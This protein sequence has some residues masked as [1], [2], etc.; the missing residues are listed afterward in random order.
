MTYVHY[1]ST[2]WPPKKRFRIVSST[3]PILLT[4]LTRIISVGSVLEGVIKRRF[5]IVHY[6]SL[7][8]A[9]SKI[10]LVAR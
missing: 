9:N 3:A 5:L 4:V 7:G 1:G 10:I 2:S 6:A 8:R